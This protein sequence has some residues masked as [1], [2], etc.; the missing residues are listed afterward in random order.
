MYPGKKSIKQ[1]IS[2]RMTTNWSA[3]WAHI[4]TP[5][6][7]AQE[8]IQE[9]AFTAQATTGPDTRVVLRMKGVE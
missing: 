6:K 2:A 3:L 7:R 9:E 4:R 8:R 1:V 5:E